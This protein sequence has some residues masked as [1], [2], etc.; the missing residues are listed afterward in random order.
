M[1]FE[2]MIKE[3]VGEKEHTKSSKPN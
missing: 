1:D 3:S 2:S